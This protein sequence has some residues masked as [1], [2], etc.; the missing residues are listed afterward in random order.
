MD[1]RKTM[2]INEILIGKCSRY[3]HANICE[4]IS[5]DK[6]RFFDI[7]APRYH[8]WIKPDT[9]GK[10]IFQVGNVPKIKVLFRCA[11]NQ[12]LTNKKLLTSSWTMS[13]N[14]LTVK[15]LPE[16]KN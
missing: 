1:K 13:K 3:N 15:S 12:T 10:R 11:G 8:R 2:I 4:Q 6:S 5:L 7:F 16:H 14:T 9:A